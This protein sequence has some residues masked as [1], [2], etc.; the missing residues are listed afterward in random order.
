MPSKYTDEIYKIIV[1]LEDIFFMGR[2]P[3]F[4][5][6]QKLAI[7]KEVKKTSI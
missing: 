3:K 5:P 7:L 1:Y 2:K 6:E 4:S